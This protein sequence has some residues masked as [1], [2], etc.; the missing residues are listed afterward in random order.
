M[1]INKGV[2]FIETVLYTFFVVLVVDKEGNKK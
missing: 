2:E 1:S